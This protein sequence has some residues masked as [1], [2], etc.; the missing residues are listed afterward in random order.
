MSDPTLLTYSLA[1][2]DE[3][4]LSHRQVANE[5]IADAGFGIEP[6]VEA[7]AE[8]FDAALGGARPLASPAEH[9]R[10]YNWDAIAEQA[11]I[12]DRR[13]SDGAW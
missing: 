3:N 6:T 13:A 1:S 2:S 7:L 4:V 9:T 10:K 12:A 11:G 5:V 8:R